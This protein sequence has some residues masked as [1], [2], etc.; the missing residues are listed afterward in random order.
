[1]A[2][3]S[4]KI[5]KKEVYRE[6]SSLISPNSPSWSALSSPSGR[7]FSSLVSS[8]FAGMLSQ[9]QILRTVELFEIPQQRKE[10]SVTV[11]GTVN[12]TVTILY[13]N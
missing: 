8:K 6:S 2:D 11:S 4:K 1:M 7:D 9:M 3:S 13:Q 10:F 5:E 12:C